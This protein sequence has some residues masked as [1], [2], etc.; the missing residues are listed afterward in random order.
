M[1]LTLVGVFSW[2]FD[3]SGEFGE[4]IDAGCVGLGVSGRQFG[5][6]AIK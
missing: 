6:A 2:V 3:V 1:L 5:E 4:D